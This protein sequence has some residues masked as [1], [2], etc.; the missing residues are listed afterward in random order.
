MQIK[1]SKV[2]CYVRPW[3]LEQFK[4]LAEN[5]FP[6]SE[7]EFCSEHKSIDRLELSDRYYKSLKIDIDT[8]KNSTAGNQISSEECNDIIERCR[9][10]RSLSREKAEKHL[11]AMAVSVQ[12]ILNEEKPDY[13]LSLT[14]DSY[15][16][17]LIRLFSEKSN[18]KFIGLIP[19][20]INGFYRISSRGEAN[21]NNAPPLEAVNSIKSKLLDKTY[22]P[23]FISKA[24]NNQTRIVFKR[25]ISNILRVPYFTFK[26]WLSGDYYN[27]HYW[28]SQIIPREFISF[29][30]PKLHGDA[31][32]KKQTENT[33]K[34]ILYIPLQM[35]P[36]CTV[37][38]W[39]DELEYT[40]YYDVLEKFIANKHQ[41]FHILI[42]EHP[43][44]AG[45]RPSSFYAKLNSDKRITIVPTFVPS[46][47]V[48]DKSNAVVIN[49]GTVGF[50]SALRGKAVL[51][52]SNVYYM[53]GKRFLKI[54]TETNS[55]II[56]N[57]IETCE[58]ETVTDTEQND[59]ILNLVN[60]LFEG[61][62][63]NDGSWSNENLGDMTKVS[64]M[65]D[66][67]RQHISFVN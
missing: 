62:F 64:L 52:F 7:I 30:P 22:T 66:S 21:V 48:L 5:A 38:Y 45:N 3:N 8:L 59:L 26:R 53:S 4:H 40:K 61:S 42:K 47:E 49:T 55:A 35:F 60:Q 54:K 24:I 19:T 25:W 15:I 16:I 50:E 6:D 51:A 13:I 29:F 34:P 17:D 2:I 11:F 56:K 46:N 20:F 9:L 41:D 36:E 10:L 67:L 57:H 37:D 28:V 1:K 33:N 32:W 27:Y 18:V 39:C 65:A 14:V 63:I 12:E 31:D 43:G 44:V 58:N 23:A